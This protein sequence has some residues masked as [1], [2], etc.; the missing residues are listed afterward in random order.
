[1]RRY[2]RLDYIAGTLATWDRDAQRYASETKI[3]MLSSLF[4]E[5]IAEAENLAIVKLTA[6]TRVTGWSRMIFGLH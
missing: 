2:G 6:D 5:V 4:R 3:E 1:V